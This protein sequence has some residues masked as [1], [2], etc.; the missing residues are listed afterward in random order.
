[1]CTVVGF[2]PRGGMVDNEIFHKR[3]AAFG[4]LMEEGGVRGLHAFGI[5]QPDA[6]II[7]SSV[8]SEVA[9]SFDPEIPA[10]AHCRYSTSGDASVYENNQPILSD[11]MALVFNG[12][13]HMGT[14]E[15]FNRHYNVEC[16]S[17][18]DGEVFL[19]LIQKSREYIEEARTLPGRILEIHGDWSFAGL[20]M[21]DFTRPD[22][23]IWV[24][25]NGKR[26]LWICTDYLGAKWYASTRDIF[27]RAG[28]PE[29]K[30]HPSFIG[31]QKA[32]P[33]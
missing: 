7:K 16:S 21:D 20:W 29:D 27:M 11:K 10:I 4:S 25:R 26:P 8:L 22:T 14:R 17:A 12:V 1:M 19:K 3:R 31:V 33:R 30:V 23:P 9:E 32:W 24:G 28:F 2:F 18:N 15:E 5:C 6:K 13:I